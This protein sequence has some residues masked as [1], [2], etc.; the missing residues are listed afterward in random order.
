MDD[1]GDKAG[2]E[3]ER[4]MVVVQSEEISMYR[5]STALDGVSPSRQSRNG[6]D[7]KDVNPYRDV[8]ACYPALS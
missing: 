8:T 4:T 3:G 2:M 7:V 5:L 6:K 1:E